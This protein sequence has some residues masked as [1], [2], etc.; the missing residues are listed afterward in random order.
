MGVPWFWV[1]DEVEGVL[2]IESFAGLKVSKGEDSD[3]EGDEWLDWLPDESESEDEGVRV[4]VGVEG[5]EGV[6]DS[7]DAG[8]CF[9]I[10]SRE[11]VSK[12]NKRVNL[13]LRKDWV[14]SKK[15]LHQV[16]L[17]VP[18]FSRKWVPII[19][20]AYFFTAFFCSFAHQ[21]LSNWLICDII[22]KCSMI[23]STSK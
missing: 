23:L 17:Q 19:L 2:R 21:K 18:S 9:L 15:N 6:L 7:T 8:L 3:V 14:S 13:L 22:G 11:K 10:P 5:A 12:N 1:M 4:V 16:P 20:G